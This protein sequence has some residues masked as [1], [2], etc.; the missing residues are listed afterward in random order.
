M[1]KQLS[2]M[3]R[4]CLAVSIYT[5]AIEIGSSKKP[6]YLWEMIS[7]RYKREHYFKLVGMNGFNTHNH[8]ILN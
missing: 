1:V 5:N 4:M 6:Y 3:K 7:M 2:E 8:L